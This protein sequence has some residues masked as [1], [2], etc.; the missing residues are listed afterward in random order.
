[1]AIRMRT[2]ILGRSQVPSVAGLNFEQVVL[3]ITIWQERHYLRV[4]VHESGPA[5]PGINY[6]SGGERAILGVIKGETYH[7]NIITVEQRLGKLCLLP[8]LWRHLA[9]KS[10]H[11]NFSGHSFAPRNARTIPLHL[12]GPCLGL[13]KCLTRLT[14]P[15]R[16]T[17]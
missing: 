3:C 7:A 5:L 4:C 14:V 11:S 8:A 16:S 12:P 2:G 13:T 10:R 9:A 1:M 6:S 15:A 17:H